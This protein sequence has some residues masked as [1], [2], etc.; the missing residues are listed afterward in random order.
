MRSACEGHVNGMGGSTPCWFRNHDDNKVKSTLFSSS[1]GFLPVL[2]G[3]QVSIMVTN[4]ESYGEV[5]DS[6]L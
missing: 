5:N 1:D 3:Y 4:C 2:V 6:M